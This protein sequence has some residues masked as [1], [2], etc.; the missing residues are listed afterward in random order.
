MDPFDDE[1]SL[2]NL[3]I[4]ETTA[5]LEDVLRALTHAKRVTLERRALDPK[6]PAMLLGHALVALH[7]LEQHQVDALVDHQRERRARSPVRKARAVSSMM[8]TASQ[9]ISSAVDAMHT[10]HGIV[11]AI[12]NGAKTR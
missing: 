6:A 11:S 8:A 12:A 5:T 10:T 1:H 9:A 4:K 2:G 3:A 7:I